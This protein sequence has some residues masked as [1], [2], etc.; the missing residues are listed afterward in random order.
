MA[1]Y[2][3]HPLISPETKKPL[4]GDSRVLEELKEI[5]GVVEDTRRDRTRKGD[6]NDG[7]LI[8]LPDSIIPKSPPPTR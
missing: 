8:P 6:T 2:K 1:Y 3:A 7:P 4:Y 5:K